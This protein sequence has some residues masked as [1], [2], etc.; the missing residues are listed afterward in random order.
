MKNKIITSLIILIFILMI[1]TSVNAAIEIKPGT[2]THTNITVSNSYQYCYNM[3]N[4]TSSLGNNTLDSHLT[5]NKDWGAVAYLGL[6]GYGS[7]T[8]STGDTTT[9]NGVSYTTTTGNPTGV[10]NFGKTYTQ[11]A[12][13]AE[14]VEKYNYN[15]CRNIYDNTNSEYVE[16]INAKDGSQQIG[17]SI[18]ETLGWKNAP[19]R[20]INSRDENSIIY[21]RTGIWG[22]D[23]LEAGKG[24]YSQGKAFQGATY[25]PVLW[26]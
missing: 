24:W 19:G 5:L 25:R 22:F 3:R 15:E 13:V 6:S 18:S 26:N 17:K 9:V 2:T 10:L 20:L 12:G 23:G 16:I 11:T 8:S 1:A 21:I 14:G 4:P 7:V